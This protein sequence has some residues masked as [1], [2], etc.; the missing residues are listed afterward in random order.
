[1]GLNKG[2]N[3]IKYNFFKSQS[4]NAHIII[5]ASSK[6]GRSRWRYQIIKNNWCFSGC[7]KIS[8]S[9]IKFYFARL[10]SCRRFIYGRVSIVIKYDLVF[11]IL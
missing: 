2:K 8:R 9:A 3:K 1:M 4:N 6:I 7:K 10:E 11:N 5:D